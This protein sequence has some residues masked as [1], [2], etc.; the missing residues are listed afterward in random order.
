[1]TDLRESNENLWLLPASP[2]LWA[3]HFLL[4]YATAAL[5]CGKFAGP[6][7]SL[8]PA[9]LAIAFYTVVALAAIGIIGWRGYLRHRFGESPLPHDFDSV[10][11]RHRFLGFAT[12]LLS[13][14][15]FVATVYTA[16]A[17]IFLQSCA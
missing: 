6:Y 16:L 8:L 9:R 15:S 10:E 5:W 11:D 3:G 14:L 13:G 1:M 12:F 17:A 2:A 7:G 4:C